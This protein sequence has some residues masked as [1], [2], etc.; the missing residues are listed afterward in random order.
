MIKVTTVKT[1]T[2]ILPDNYKELW[3]KDNFYDE[4]DEEYEEFINMTDEEFLSDMDLIDDFPDFD[5]E[6]DEKTV[7]EKI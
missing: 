4:E 2:I 5:I 3:L 6:E 1:T 7:I